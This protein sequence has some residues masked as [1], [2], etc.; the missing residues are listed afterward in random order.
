VHHIGIGLV[1]GNALLDDGAAVLVERN[2]AVFVDARKFQAARLGYERVEFAVA[3]PSPTPLLPCGDLRGRWSTP[4][5]PA[6]HHFTGAAGNSAGP[7]AA[8][9]GG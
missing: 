4:A 9:R 7:A 5:Q 2:P 1:E 3:P 6:H 8:G